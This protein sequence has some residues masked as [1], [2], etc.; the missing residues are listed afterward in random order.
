MYLEKR[1]KQGTSSKMN[2]TKSD[3]DEMVWDETE[4]R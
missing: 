2:G 3:S 1:A 4:V